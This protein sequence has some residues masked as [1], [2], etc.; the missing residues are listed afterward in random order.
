M[1]A[2]KS[3]LLSSLGLAFAAPAP[4]REPTVLH[5]DQKHPAA[6]DGGPGTAERPFR[7]INA[8]AQV[9]QPGDTVR[10]RAGI[11]RER[12]A[13]ARGGEPGRP[14]VYEAAPGERVHVRG[15][16]VWAP[17][18]EA[19]PEVPGLYSA[20]F[21]L[22]LQG[23]PNPFRISLRRMPNPLQSCG[24]VFVDG[25]LFTQA[26]SRA[27]VSRGPGTW[28]FELRGPPARL[29]V[30][31]GP[32]RVPAQSTV[33]V[34]VRERIFAPHVR[35]LGHI[36]VRGFHFE[37]AANQFP[38]GFWHPNDQGYPQAGAV[39]TRSGHHWTI[40]HNVIRWANTI[41]LDIGTEGGRDLE[42]EQPKPALFGRH[43]IA[44]NVI[45]DNGAGGIAGFEAEYCTIVGNVIERNNHLGFTAPE[46]A[47]IKLHF[48]IGTVIE[49]NLVRDNYAFGI[50][51]DNVFHNA[52]ISRNVVL[53]NNIGIFVEMGEGPILV[54]HNV[55]AGS[56][57][58]D[59]IYMHDA[60]RATIVHNLIHGS[61]HFGLYIRVV[62]DRTFRRADGTRAL[63]TGSENVV[64]NNV[65]FDNWRGHISWP[66]PS[67]R[68]RDNV[69]DYNLFLNGA[70][71]HWEGLG[72]HRFN[73]NG[74]T[75]PALVPIET[76]ASGVERALIEAGHPTELMPN[77]RLWRDM[78]YLGL[79]EWRIVTGQDRN[80]HAPP[81]RSGVI[82]VG[83][84][85]RGAF[86]LSTAAADMR[87]RHGEM[88]HALQVPP[89]E[90]PTH[91]LF[92]QPLPPA[93]PRMPG[94]IQGIP[95]GESRYLLWP[96]PAEVSAPGLR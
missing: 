85:E 51:V 67:D 63:V 74:N 39:G 53:G 43:R 79:E 72:F 6:D 69:S 83:A 60:S 50:W 56:R 68:A 28:Y 80:S 18:W 62:A 64:R 16:E 54:D 27:E 25:Q 78:P 73:L 40:E 15:S 75:G 57:D 70:K 95:R 33:E 77:F 9:A 46:V 41:G 22:D 24:Q 3:L 5:V 47:G 20:P 35:G 45:S 34:S 2:W 48:C 94:P 26:V 88:F 1:I 82:E 21:D 10:V 76:I 14:I 19:D 37:H 49:A 58:G 7:T 29:F 17:Q 13:P 4:A 31:F 81:V 55:V 12:V 8:A 92:G 23:N 42:G 71:S 87:I 61:A 59:G 65:F 91:D 89:F 86:H 96:V 66:W 30:N 90:G 38:S 11:Y 32:H 93:G 84:V 36:T 44:H 52:R